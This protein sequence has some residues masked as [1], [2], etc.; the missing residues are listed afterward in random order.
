MMP[1]FPYRFP[2]LN[3]SKSNNLLL[4]NACSYSA[5]ESGRQLGWLLADRQSPPWWKWN[6]W[7]DCLLT[8]FLWNSPFLWNLLEF[9]FESFNSVNAWE[10]KT[11]FLH[12]L[13]IF[14]VHI[15]SL[16]KPIVYEELLWEHGPSLTNILQIDLIHYRFV[17]TG[18]GLYILIDNVQQQHMLK[19]SIPDKWFF[20]TT[21]MSPMLYFST[22]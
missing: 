2:S 16:S 18:Y 1:Q 8:S 13:I 7:R 22:W 5:S 21:S 4:L 11:F 17:S 6:N 19:C 9:V 15:P 12:Q 10:W 3:R 14:T 20:S